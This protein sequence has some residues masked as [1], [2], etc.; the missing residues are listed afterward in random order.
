MRKRGDEIGTQWRTQQQQLQQRQNSQISTARAALN[1]IPVA[2]FN[3][4]VYPIEVTTGTPITCL[5]TN[6]ST[7]KVVHDWWVDILRDSRRTFVKD[8][9]I[10]RADF[11]LAECENRS[12]T[13]ILLP[14][15]DDM[16][17]A[18]GILEKLIRS[19]K[20]GDVGSVFFLLFALLVILPL[21]AM[22]LELVKGHDR[23]VYRPEIVR[24]RAANVLKFGRCNTS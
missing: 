8:Y 22:V 16:E 19:M 15:E 11:P 12:F 1:S 23:R 4:S 10:I 9:A 21:N 7:D 17:D 18:G 6:Y 5:P 13:M 2:S 3:F 14:R 20:S 24:R